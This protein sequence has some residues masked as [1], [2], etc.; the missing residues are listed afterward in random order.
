MRTTV[1]GRSRDQRQLTRLGQW[2][3]TAF[4]RGW[5]PEECVRLLLDAPGIKVDQDTANG[6]TPLFIAA[7]GGHAEC[8]RLLLDPPGIEVHQDTTNALT[9][10][11]MAA[12]EGHDS[13]D[14]IF[15][16]APGID[17]LVAACTHVVDSLRQVSSGNATYNIVCLLASRKAR[18]Q[19]I[20]CEIQPAK[21]RSGVVQRTHCTHRCRGA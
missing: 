7:E 15:R 3:D 2:Y 17:V 12:Q 11:H 14:E 1:A 20:S 5:G 21:I 19:V 18:S 9:P 4:Y 10:L 6:T 8:V 13:G 16:A